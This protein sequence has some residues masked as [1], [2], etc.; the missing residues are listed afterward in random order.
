MPDNPGWY[1]FECGPAAF[2]GGKMYVVTYSKNPDN[3]S[4]PYGMGRL[5]VEHG[6]TY[7]GPYSSKQQA[8]EIAVSMAQE[9]GAK[10]EIM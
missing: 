8:Y 2:L 3:W 5:S 4:R 7:D 1:I 9:D 10:V 6:A